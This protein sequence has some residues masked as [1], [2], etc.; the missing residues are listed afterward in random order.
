MRDAAP[1]KTVLVLA[2]LVVVI[3]G[4][5]VA[6]GF[7]LPFITALF[8]AVISAPVVRFLENRARLPEALAIL[9]TVLLDVGLVV[10]FGALLWTSL[11][12][13]VEAVP[14]YQ[15]ALDNL[16]HSAVDA[17][18][19]WRLPVDYGLLEE[20]QSA[21]AVMGVVGD[22]VH[23][24]TQIVSNTLMV[25]LLLGFLLFET[26][27][28]REKLHLLLGRANPHIEKTAIAAYEVQRYLVVKTVLSVLT[29]VLT[30]CWMAVCGLDFPLLWGLLAFLLNY[31]PS[32]GPAISLVPPV[33]VA[34]LTLGPGGAAAVAA[35]HLS[36]G[37]VIGNVLEPR[38]M[39]KTLGLS[40]LVVFVSMFFFFWLW[41]PVGAL[42]AAPLTMLLRSALEVN[43]ET[44]WIAI[45]LGSHEYVESKRREWGWK[46][47]DE[48]ASGMPPPPPPP[49][50]REGEVKPP[51][52][53][54]VDEMIDTLHQVREPGVG[55]DA[56]E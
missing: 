47:L 44:R 2:A 27:G 50:S 42:F 19:V 35:G 43:E 25:L 6:G 54:P 10:G 26:R 16:A 46:T 4:L 20:L 34:L 28:A 15:L 40:T 24:V 30:G 8:L 31:I 56:A 52:A 7:F 14:R 37:F 1:V 53:P 39:G 23:E 13:F 48:R 32:L 41:G 21:G 36:I 17:A 29:G 9:L 11:P 49:P 38:L 18:R 3:A 55:K 5:R 45:L 22:L 51:E 33:L 12:G